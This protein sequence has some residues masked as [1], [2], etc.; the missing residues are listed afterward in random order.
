MWIFRGFFVDSFKKTEVEFWGFVDF[1]WIFRGF[2]GG[3]FVDSLKTLWIFHGFGWWIYPGF[4]VD[5]GWIP[6]ISFVEEMGDSVQDF[7]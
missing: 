2:V 6:W 5:L 3:F 7:R 1:S 4:G